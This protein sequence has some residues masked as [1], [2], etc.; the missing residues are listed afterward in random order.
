M[1]CWQILSDRQVGGRR[2]NRFLAE[3]QKTNK[4]KDGFT[5]WNVR[6]AFRKPRERMGTLRSKDSAVTVRD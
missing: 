6:T 5:P 3:K 1:D 2:S 4:R